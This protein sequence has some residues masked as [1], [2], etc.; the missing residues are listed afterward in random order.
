MAPVTDFLEESVR[1]YPRTAWCC[2][3][4][5]SNLDEDASGLAEALAVAAKSEA[6][7]LVL[8]T[9]QDSTPLCTTGGTRD[10]ADL[11]LP[12]YRRIWPTPSLPPVSLL[13]SSW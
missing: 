1:P 6:V 7:V 9:T 4:R 3:P 2:T 10:S 8:R 13:W 12:E 5:C 11:R